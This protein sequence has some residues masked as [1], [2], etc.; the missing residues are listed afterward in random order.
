MKISKKK[1]HLNVNCQALIDA[2]CTQVQIFAYQAK[3]V[4]ICAKMFH[5]TVPLTLI[6]MAYSAP[7]CR[8]A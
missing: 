4:K 6:K 7:R 1:K 8:M 5:D 2:S 3:K